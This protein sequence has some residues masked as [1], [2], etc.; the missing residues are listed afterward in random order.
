MKY[1]KFEELP[2]WNMSIEITRTIYDLSSNMKWN[3]D[4]GL[5]DQIR[6]AIISVSSNIVE[7]FEKSNN[8]E[9]IRFLRMTKGSIGEV[10]NQLYIGLTLN[11]ISKDEFNSVNIKLEN[12]ASQVGGLIVYLDKNRKSR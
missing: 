11:Y 1:K 9:F 8:N 6:R 2:I 10:R 7:G 12:L 4:F 3:R 5:R